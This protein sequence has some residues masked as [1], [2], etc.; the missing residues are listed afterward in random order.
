MANLLLHQKSTS[1]ELDSR[2][3]KSLSFTQNSVDT[4]KN[5]YILHHSSSGNNLLKSENTEAR[6][7]K[8]AHQ[9]A[10]M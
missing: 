4:Q 10:D 6:F 7:S 8:Q 3:N 1:N 5:Q 2:N 9:I